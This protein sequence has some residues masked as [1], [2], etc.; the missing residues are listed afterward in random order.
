[1]ARRREGSGLFARVAPAGASNV[2]KEW[3]TV[4]RWRAG[5][6]EW[7]RARGARESELRDVDAS[8]FERLAERQAENVLRQLERLDIDPVVAAEI[9]SIDPDGSYAMILTVKGYKGVQRA[10]DVA[11]VGRG[12]AMWERVAYIAGVEENEI[13]DVE[14]VALRAFKDD[15]QGSYALWSTMSVETATGERFRGLGDYVRWRNKRDSRIGGR[16][17]ARRG[18][19]SYAEG[20]RISAAQRAADLRAKRS[21]DKLRQLT[22]RAK[23][24]EEGGARG[25]AASL[26]KAAK[27]LER[28]I[29][30]ARKGKKR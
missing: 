3:S 7:R 20:K 8:T 22:K 18:R 19:R 25:L 13:V 15:Y 10:K 23:T 16:P 27:Q 2:P 24:L 26:R 21:R 11:W 9:A 29:K 17:K 14:F 1:V 6:T 28:R 4:E 30:A 5:S 12:R